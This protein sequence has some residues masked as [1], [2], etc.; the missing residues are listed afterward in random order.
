MAL[1]QSFLPQLHE[2]QPGLSILL[3]YNGRGIALSTALGKHL[4]ARLSGASREFPFPVTPIRPIPLH[5]LQ[6]LYLGAG[7]A[8][9]RL[10][11]ALR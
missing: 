3:G 7:I 2:P 8:W 6:R 4:A 9:Y 1:N 5:G 10:L 11:D